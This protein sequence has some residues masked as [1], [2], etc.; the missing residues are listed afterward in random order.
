M[1]HHEKHATLKAVA[2]LAN[3]RKGFHKKRSRTRKHKLNSEKKGRTYQLNNKY[4]LTKRHN[5]SRLT[6]K[7][8]RGPITIIQHLTFEFYVLL[9]L[10]PNY[11]LKK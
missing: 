6:I 3:F 5:A 10:L 7:P 8:I 4:T 2:G 1:T 9:K 11:Y